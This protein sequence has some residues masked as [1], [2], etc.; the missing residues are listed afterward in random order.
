M[1][2]YF[3]MQLNENE[4]FNLASS[5]FAEAIFLTSANNKP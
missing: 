2:T 1:L 5:Q 3:F 4:K